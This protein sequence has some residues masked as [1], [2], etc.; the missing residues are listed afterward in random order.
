MSVAALRPV[1]LTPIFH[2]WSLAFEQEIPRDALAYWNA[3]RA[4][5]A[6]PRASDISAKGM[7]KFLTHVSL[8]EILTNI[9]G[10]VDYFVRLTGERVREL[11][12]PVAHKKLAEFLPGEMEE[13]WRGM[14]DLVRNER[15]PLRVHGR[16]SYGG[17]IW[18]YQETLLAPL[19][20]ED[21]QP[22]MFLMVTAWT[23]YKSANGE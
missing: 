23:P 15:R 7:K 19:G 5:R 16:M 18:L 14:L 3:C 22:G 9:D 17:H 2:D 6:M 21:D 10:S 13:R 20:D 11:Y 4:T 8:L 1:P 12:G